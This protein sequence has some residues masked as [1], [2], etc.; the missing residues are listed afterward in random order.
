METIMAAKF[1]LSELYK[2]PGFVIRRCHQ[3][4]LSVFAEECKDLALTTTQYGSMYILMNQPGIDQITLA[5][6]LGVDRST[7]ALVVSGLEKRSILI[8]KIYE[9]DKR[10]RLLFLTEEG[11]SLLRQAMPKAQLAQ[12]RLM[13]AFNKKERTQ[14]LRLLSKLVDA[15]QSEIRVPLKSNST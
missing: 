14:L 3:L 4:A 1:A 10:K 8:R 6:L 5:G 13:K 2:R 15:N 9:N 11:I 12:V 7:T